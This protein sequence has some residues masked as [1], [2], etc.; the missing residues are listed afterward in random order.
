[1]KFFFTAHGKL[2]AKRCLRRWSAAGGDATF[3][4]VD[5]VNGT[6]TQRIARHIKGRK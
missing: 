5:N 4:R 2:E 1:M 3:C 6:F